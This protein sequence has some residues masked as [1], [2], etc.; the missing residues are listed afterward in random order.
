[1]PHPKQKRSSTHLP[2][3]LLMGQS[4]LTDSASEGPTH[5]ELD[6]STVQPTAPHVGVVHKTQ[7]QHQQA[8]QSVQ[9]KSLSAHPGSK[10][11]P[12]L[13]WMRV[14]ISIEGGM[15]VPLQQVVGLHPLALAA[16]QTGMHY[17][18][19]PSTATALWIRL[20]QPS[21]QTFRE[22]HRALP[23]PGCCLACVGWWTQQST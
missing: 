5:A 22:I 6:G 7:P 2:G 10:A 3:E 18:P 17:T 14:P 16:L 21:F 19:D 4:T 15:G 12:V 1:M 11:L 13:P 23:C 8:T 20:P 9:R